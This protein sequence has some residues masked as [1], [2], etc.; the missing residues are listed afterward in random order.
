VVCLRKL[1]TFQFTF[2]IFV[3]KLEGAQLF[4]LAYRDEKVKEIA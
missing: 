4:L 2:L 3:E 1:K